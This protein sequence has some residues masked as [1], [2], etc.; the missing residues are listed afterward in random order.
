MKKN[1]TALNIMEYI[2]WE[3]WEKTVLQQNWS[4]LGVA[5]LK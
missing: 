2:I 5:A 1:K 4:V 3:N